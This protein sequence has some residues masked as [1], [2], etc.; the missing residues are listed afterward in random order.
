M[1]YCKK[2]CILLGVFLLYAFVFVFTKYASLQEPLSFRYFFCLAGAFGVM[3]VY[4]VLWQQVLKRIPLTD[5]YMFKGSSLIFLLILSSVLFGESITLTN[6]I[7]SII[8]VGGIALFAK[9]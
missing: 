5:A 9:A 8:I 4:A 6:V 1:K 2:Y 3:G 7:G